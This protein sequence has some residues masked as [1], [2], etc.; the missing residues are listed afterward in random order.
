MKKKIT[1]RITALAVLLFAAMVVFTGCSKDEDKDYLYTIGIEDYSHT[2]VG[3]SSTSP[4]GYLSG[5]NIADGFTITAENESDADVQA[6]SRFEAE[7][8]K[9]DLAQLN[10]SAA[11]GTYSFRY[12]LTA[13]TGE[14][15]L[16]DRRFTN[17]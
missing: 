7:M 9:I 2:I 11:G 12:V 17:R 10:A 16:S 15:L 13:I 4:I 3:E 6:L 14:K 8:G 1:K 5:L